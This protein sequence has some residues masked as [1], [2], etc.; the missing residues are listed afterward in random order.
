MVEY[1]IM[2]GACGYNE[3]VQKADYP[4]WWNLSVRFLSLANHEI[5]QRQ[6]SEF[7]ESL[8]LPELKELLAS[9]AI[10]DCACGEVNPPNFSECWK[11][12]RPSPVAPRE[13]SERRID[14]G[15]GNPWEA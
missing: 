14:I 2:C 5:T 15:G 4:K 1:Q 3:F 7:A 8:N 9:G 11:C 6:F 10:W 13:T 12:S